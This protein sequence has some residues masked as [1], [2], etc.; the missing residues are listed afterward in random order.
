VPTH[1]AISQGGYEPDK[2]K[3]DDAAVEQIMAY[4]LELLRRLA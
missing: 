1:E 3:V 2:R 4:S